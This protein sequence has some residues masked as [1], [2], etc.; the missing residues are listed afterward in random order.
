M[1]AGG[2]LAASQLASANAG[3][4]IQNIESSGVADDDEITELEAAE[5]EGPVDE[6]GVDAKDIELVVQQV[7]CSRAKAVKALKDNGGDLINASTLSTYS[8][9]LLKLIVVLFHS[10]GCQRV[11][12]DSR[13]SLL[14]ILL[15]ASL[16]LQ[17]KAFHT[18][19]P[20]LRKSS[21]S[22]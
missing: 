14:C 16:Y 12:S 6:T 3:P 8:V 11:I 20:I 1:N 5:D 17:S 2:P 15:C 4:G 18:G 7:G 22:Q 21:S 19:I 10:H 13:V 9:Y